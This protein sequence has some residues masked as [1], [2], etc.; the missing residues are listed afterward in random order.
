VPED[1]SLVGFD[2]IPMAGWNSYALTTLRQ[3]AA[4]MAREVIAILDR[5]DAEPE[6][7]PVSVL[8]PV[9]LVTRATVRG[10]A[11]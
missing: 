1:V 6:L 8:F 2:D 4:R 11:S 7:A 10:L 3:D 9:D 5:R